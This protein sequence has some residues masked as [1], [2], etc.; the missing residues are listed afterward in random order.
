MQKDNNLQISEVLFLA[1]ATRPSQVHR[2][3]VLLCF[4]FILGPRLPKQP[5]SGM[6]PALDGFSLTVK[7]SLF[8]IIHWNKLITHG[9]IP[10]Q[11]PQAAILPCVWMLESLGILS[12]PN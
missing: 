9:L 2:L 7:W 3:H 10:P 5:L 11:G 1:Q 12:D 4:V 6:S 8:L